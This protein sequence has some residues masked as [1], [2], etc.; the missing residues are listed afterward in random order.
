MHELNSYSYREYQYTNNHV[1]QGRIF[2][3]EC[4][5]MRQILQRIKYSHPYIPTGF[6]R[7]VSVPYS[8]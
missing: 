8:P 3:A 1:M 4:K 5:H 7:Q 6:V 2:C